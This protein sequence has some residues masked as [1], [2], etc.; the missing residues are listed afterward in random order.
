MYLPANTNME[1]NSRLYRRLVV[2]VFVAFTFRYSKKKIV[3][4]V[5]FT[6]CTAC[7]AKIEMSLVVRCKKLVQSFQVFASSY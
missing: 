7:A 6:L 5:Y 1:Q 4:P 2:N 3:L